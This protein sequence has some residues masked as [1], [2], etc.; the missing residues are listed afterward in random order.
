MARRTCQK[1]NM[2][3][4]TRGT[5]GIQDVKMQMQN[6]FMVF[7]HTWWEYTVI[8]IFAV[9]RSRTSAVCTR[10]DDLS[11]EWPFMLLQRLE[12]LILRLATRGCFYKVEINASLRQKQDRIVRWTPCCCSLFPSIRTPGICFQEKKATLIS[13]SCRCTGTIWLA[14]RV[15]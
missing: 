1:Q 13:V 11:S 6:K 7:K 8:Y 4:R 15:S 10:E 5:A 3:D 9:I 2:I 12:L 14:K